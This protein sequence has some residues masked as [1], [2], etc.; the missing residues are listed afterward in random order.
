MTLGDAG[1]WNGPGIAE[2]QGKGEMI[3]IRSNKFPLAEHVEVLFSN[4]E[5]GFEARWSTRSGCIAIVDI[6]TQYVINDAMPIR[7]TREEAEACA[8]KMMRC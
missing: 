7:K 8:R 5:D 2:R 6:E 1:I 3:I 4:P